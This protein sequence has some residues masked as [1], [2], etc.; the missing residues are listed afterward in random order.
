METMKREEGTYFLTMDVSSLYSNIKHEIGITCFEETLKEDPEIPTTQREFFMKALHL[1]LENNFFNCN[2]VMYH[3]KKGTAMGTRI[4][5]SYA[6]LFMGKFEQRFITS[7]IPFV[8]NI[9]MYRRYIDDLFFLWQGT[10]EEARLFTE[11]INENQ[12]GHHLHPQFPR[13]KY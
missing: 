11:H 6:N 1:I 12:W 3:Q 7:G 4:A 13:Q 5:P 9:N 2:G 8:S 10:E